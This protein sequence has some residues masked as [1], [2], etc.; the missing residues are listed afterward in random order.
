MAEFQDLSVYEYS[1]S[2]KAMV[3]VG[4]LGHDYGFPTG[5]PAD[6]VVEQLIIRAAEQVNVMRGTH[7][8][9][10]C[11]EESPIRILSPLVPKGWVSL[12]MGEIHVQGLNRVVFA[13]PTLV[14][15]YITAHQYLPPE[16]FLVALLEDC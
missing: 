13:A 11:D 9:P 16:P 15:H 3:N 12:G 7:D 4:W 2:D 14:I 8:C 5:H 6:E 1:P 10:F